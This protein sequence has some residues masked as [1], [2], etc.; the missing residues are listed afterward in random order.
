MGRSIDSALWVL[1]SIAK[2]WRNELIH[3]SV[4]LPIFYHLQFC[5]IFECFLVSESTDLYDLNL[6]VGYCKLQHYFPPP[7]PTH[8]FFREIYTRTWPNTNMNGEIC[9]VGPPHRIVPSGSGVW[10]VWLADD[11][12]LHNRSPVHR[13]LRGG[14]GG[15]DTTVFYGFSFSLLC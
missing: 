11:Q 13:N 3:S 12:D 9:F 7:P 14:G 4:I 5:F 2:R 8:F 10:L 6:C 15:E 1:V